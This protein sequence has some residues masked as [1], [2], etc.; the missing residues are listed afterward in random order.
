MLTI[1][2]EKLPTYRMGMKKGIQ[3]G[4]E[5]GREEG[6]RAQALAIA[7]RLLAQGIEPK[8]VAAFTDLALAEVEALKTPPTV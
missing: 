1:D 7:A 8:Q 5:K 2:F 6:T 3:E 4:I